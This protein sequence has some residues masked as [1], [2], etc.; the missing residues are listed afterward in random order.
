MAVRLGNWKSSILI[1]LSD[2]FN[3][4]SNKPFRSNS[5]GLITNKVVVFNAKVVAIQNHLLRGHHK[6][7]GANLCIRRP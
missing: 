5:L 4:R 6:G 3:E 1:R 7:V 2:Q